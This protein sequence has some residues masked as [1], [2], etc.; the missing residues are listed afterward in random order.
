MGIRDSEVMS[1]PSPYLS[2]RPRRCEVCNTVRT[3]SA[4]A[5]T[6]NKKQRNPLQQLAVAPAPDVPYSTASHVPGETIAADNAH[7]ETC[8][9]GTGN[10]NLHQEQFHHDLTPFMVELLLM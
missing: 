3:P 2:P 4:D 8:Q 9:G 7:R 10:G 6:V 5:E 1:G